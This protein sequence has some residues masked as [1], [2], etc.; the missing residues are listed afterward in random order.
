MSFGQRLVEFFAPAGSFKTDLVPTD[1]QNALF[2]QLGIM[3]GFYMFTIATF[4]ILIGY[5]CYVAIR[6]YKD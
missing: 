5:A 3:F 6:E 4:L 2:D 1:A